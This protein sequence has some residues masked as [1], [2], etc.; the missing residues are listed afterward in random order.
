M[1][2]PETG[3]VDARDDGDEPAR[4]EV[5]LLLRSFQA[6]DGDA[7]NRGFN[8]I[9]HL[10][11]PLDEWRWKFQPESGDAWITL[12]FEASGELVAHFGVVRHWMWVHGERVVA[13]QAVDSY[14]LRR[15]GTASQRVFIDT[16]REFYRVH[17]DGERIAFLFGF[18]GAHHMGLGRS[19]LG[20]VD[21]VP[22]PVWHRRRPWL[23]RRRPSLSHRVD[24]GFA[25]E[26]LDRLW[27][28]AR[29]R[30]P[31]AVIRDGARWERRYHSRPGSRY[32]YAT[33]RRDGEIEAWAVF[34]VDGPTLRWV[35]LLWDGGDA[36]A[37]AALDEAALDAAAHAGVRR[38]E[39]WLGG[40]EAAAAALAARGWTRGAHPQGLE[41]TAVPFRKDVDGAAL[42]RELYFTMGDSDLI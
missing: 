31:A 14:R 6:G 40:D 3:R 25:P 17:G 9:F 12:G 30:H 15:P 33:A 34:A 1:G 19:L 42:V 23:R 13:G 35:D 41:L 5:G 24:D 2:A 28:R 21:P 39:A 26:A 4:Q 32:R 36:R 22:V 29:S 38:L 27:E 18:P 8:E 10:E 20:Y 16:V 11:R 37:I 7:I